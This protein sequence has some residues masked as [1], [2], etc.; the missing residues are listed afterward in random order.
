M[1]FSQ[2]HD[3]AVERGAD[4]RSM[5]QNA[6]DAIIVSFKNGRFLGVRK[7]GNGYPDA[8][9][10]PKR[11]GL[12]TD[13]AVGC[14]GP[15]YVI[16]QQFRGKK[17][18]ATPEAYKEH[19]S[20]LL[21]LA[22]EPGKLGKSAQRAYAVLTKNIGRIRK[23]VLKIDK[24]LRSILVIEVDGKLLC[25][26][27]GYRDWY[28]DN[29]FM[30]KMGGGPTGTCAITGREDI[31]PEI[32][33]ALHGASFASGNKPA[34]LS[35]GQPKATGSN[36]GLHTHLA[37][38]RM[39]EELESEQVSLKGLVA[40]K[41]SRCRRNVFDM[42][43][44]NGDVHLVF[45]GHPDVRPQREAASFVLSQQPTEEQDGLIAEI[46][47]RKAQSRRGSSAAGAEAWAT[48]TL[49][50]ALAGKGH[51][52]VQPDRPVTYLH[53]SGTK[54]LFVRYYERLDEGQ[55][56]LNIADY[57]DLA[58]FKALPCTS[59]VR[60][61]KGKV[62]KRPPG[63]PSLSVPVHSLVSSVV[64]GGQGQQALAD[65][66][67]AQVLRMILF[68]H[69][70]GGELLGRVERTMRRAQ[71]LPSENAPSALY[72]LHQFCLR[73]RQAIEQTGKEQ[74]MQSTEA[75]PAEYSVEGG[76]D[77]Y[78]LGAA[79]SACGELS[80]KA[81]GRP[82]LDKKLIMR[83]FGNLTFGMDEIAKK[84]DYLISYV[85][86]SQQTLRILNPVTAEL[87]ALL[88]RACRIKASGL[89]V[90]QRLVV[91]AGKYQR[92]AYAAKKSHENWK[93]KQQKGQG[94]PEEGKGAQ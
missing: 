11:T 44:K 87:K 6:K 10:R 52:G 58:K 85:E 82:G 62:Q 70:P 26:M 47:A 83:V 48:K 50:G 42:Y 64:G 5:T 27:P 7:R 20:R 55:M 3:A 9:R 84:A 94:Q 80:R 35:F 53:I 2:L 79:I 88:G 13:C 91:Q 8:V 33:P 28:F 29:W 43:R 30:R 17:V 93:Q 72:V 81:V 59:F 18:V 15:K 71:A 60:D 36:I 1:L 92:D 56:L 46:F 54:L 39:L 49:S 37:V 77:F 22:K 19:L 51:R 90:M 4:Q 67:Y 16:G 21:L 75:V 40:K 34:Q 45:S 86:Y 89:T 24:T 38:I 32:A 63:M 14:D 12:S 76:D 66:L 23:E 41:G 78:A 69:A 73:R 61:E 31:I 68:G 25:E 57:L 65:Q 74:A